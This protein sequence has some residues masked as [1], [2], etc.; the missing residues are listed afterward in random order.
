[1]QAGPEEIDRVFAAMEAWAR[2][3]RLEP[4]RLDGIRLEFADGSWLLVRRSITEPA[5]T[6]RMEAPDEQTLAALRGQA[7]RRLGLPQLQ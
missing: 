6:L 3:E 1:V 4:V 7:S 2:E 5:F